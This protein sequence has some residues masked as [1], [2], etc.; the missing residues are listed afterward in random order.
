MLKNMLSNGSKLVKYHE[1]FMGIQIWFIYIINNNLQILLTF[2]RFDFVLP[3]GAKSC[4]F[5]KNYLFLFCVSE[6]FVFSFDIVCIYIYMA[7]FLS[8]NSYNIC[9]MRC[10]CVELDFVYSRI[11]I[12]LFFVYIFFNVYFV[13]YIAFANRG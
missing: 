12:F 5:F 6:Y 11:Y 1:V 4:F 13:F 3:S 8:V 9:S 7:R 10:Q 2:C